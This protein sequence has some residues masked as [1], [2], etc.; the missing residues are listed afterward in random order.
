MELYEHHCGEGWGAGPP[1]GGEPAVGLLRRAD[2]LAAGLRGHDIK[3]RLRQQRLTRVQH[4][5]YALGH[6]VLRDEGRWLAALWACGRAAALSHTT[7]AAFHRMAAEEPGADVHVSSARRLKSRPGVVVHQT[8]HLDRRDVFA[9][10]PFVVTTIP[11]TL[12]DLADALPWDA[13]RALADRQRRL[14][15]DGIREAQAR[16][17]YRAGAPRVTRL[18]EADDA[19]TKSAFERRYLSFAAAHHVPRP[20]RLNDWVGGHKADA[21][22]TAQRLIVELDGR[23]YHERRAQ[24]RADRHRDGDYQLAGYRIQRL[25]WD[26]LHPGEAPA[27]ADRL[28][29]LLTLG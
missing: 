7:A 6:T 29:Q 23:T 19:H 4:N 22:Y 16:T 11:R 8:R 1:G 14:N 28:H 25:V 12:V 3:N 26:D 18:V 2:L 21:I 13:Y 17:P 9:R 24:M 20:D 15:V 27:T 5:V 10:G